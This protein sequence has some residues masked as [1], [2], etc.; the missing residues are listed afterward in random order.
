MERERLERIEAAKKV[1]IEEKQARKQK[2]KMRRAKF[3][4]W[5]KSLRGLVSVGVA[6]CLIALSI[7]GIMSYQVQQAQNKIIFAENLV[8]ACGKLETTL[9]HLAQTGNISGLVK[10][11]N[12]GLAKQLAIFESAGGAG[13]IEY[14]GLRNLSSA[15]ALAKTSSLNNWS[16]KVKLLE[17]LHLNKLI[18]SCDLTQRF[19]FSGSSSN[20]PEDYGSTDVYLSSVCS[21]NPK[22]IYQFQIRTTDGDWESH[23]LPVPFEKSWSCDN[24][25]PAAYRGIAPNLNFGLVDQDRLH[26]DY[27]LKYYTKDNS[28]FSLRESSDYSNLKQGATVSCANRDSRVAQ[29]RLHKVIYLWYDCTTG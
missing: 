13:S 24:V 3:F 9:G 8:K 7:F 2:R 14:E 5:L 27:R 23:T 4:G 6:L 21:T 25:S 18:T 16:S 11:D 15:L 20:D 26:S 22:T 19:F 29:V 28:Y 10:K 17:G 12:S 1:K